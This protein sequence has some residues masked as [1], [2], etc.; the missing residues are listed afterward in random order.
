MY[1]R[2]N[3]ERLIS[4][5]SSCGPTR[6]DASAGRTHWMTRSGNR[7]YEALPNDVNAPNLILN[8]ASRTNTSETIPH[9]DT[10]G[11]APPHG[12]A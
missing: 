12:P 11:T 9:V 1:S 5:I 3:R 6:E 8:A 7:A 10:A 4:A 2:T